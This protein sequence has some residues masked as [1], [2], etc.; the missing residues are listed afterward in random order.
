[1][2]LRLEHIASHTIVHKLPYIMNVNYP[3][4]AL[5]LQTLC[6]LWI[7]QVDKRAIRSFRISEQPRFPEYLEKSEQPGHNRC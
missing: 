3:D 5:G 2:E 6:S 1:M 7:M 4:M